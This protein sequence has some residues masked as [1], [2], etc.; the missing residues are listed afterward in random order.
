M[1]TLLVW[2]LGYKQLGGG[3]G[4]TA[5]LVILSCALD[6]NTLY[7]QVNMLVTITSNLRRQLPII[8]GIAGIHYFLTGQVLDRSTLISIN[9]SCNKCQVNTHS[10]YEL[11]FLLHV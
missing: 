1:W 7:C 8:I 4:R 9:G 6:E 3:R 11:F 5:N 2:D 10:E